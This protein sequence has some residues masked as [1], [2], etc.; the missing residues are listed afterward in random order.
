MEEE[1]QNTTEKKKTRHKTIKIIAILSAVLII[2]AFAGAVVAHFYMKKRV[3][4]L[5]E[6]L[7]EIG[8]TEEI[9]AED[10]KKAG[11]DLPWI[12]SHANDLS[13]DELLKLAKRL[14]VDVSQFVANEKDKKN[15]TDTPKS[16]ANKQ[17]KQSQKSVEENL[18]GNN[19][20]SQSSY[21]DWNDMSQHYAQQIIDQMI[22]DNVNYQT[23]SENKYFGTEPVFSGGSGSSQDPYRI[24]TP[25]DLVALSSKVNSG[26]ATQN[27]YFLLTN[28]LDLSGIN[29]FSPIGS[30]AYPFAGVFLGNHHTISNI[31]VACASY[32]TYNNE[33]HLAG[34]F[35]CISNATVSEL[36]LNNINIFINKNTFNIIVGGLSASVYPSSNCSF[37]DCKV[38]GV[39]EARQGSGTIIGG[40]FGD[41]Y[42]SDGK[43]FKCTR[44]QNDVKIKANGEGFFIGSVCGVGFNKGTTTYSNI[45]TRANVLN[46]NNNVNC[47]GAF[48]IVANFGGTFNAE[49]FFIR[50]TLN[51]LRTNQT[52]HTFIGDIQDVDSMSVKYSFTN[53]FGFLGDNIDLYS[54]SSP[55]KVNEQNC[56]VTKTL[57]QNC[58]FDSAIWDMTDRSSPFLK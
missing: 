42:V 50:L 13:E 38:S 5:H 35:G 16:T 36:T 48:G 26:Y 22:D 21:D 52:I 57:P 41:T 3:F 4:G 31:N 15:I 7:Q 37:Y 8:I 51:P 44:M 32:Y 23:E 18:S 20:S 28:D 33:E 11:I 1:L 45:C 54:I 29:D 2:I 55:K 12:L 46:E 40:L 49:N 17:K 34:F 25:Q 56:S 53:I 39:I 47:F 30:R 6:K 27:V 14:G 19:S 24:S 43:S 58:G 9:D 10:L